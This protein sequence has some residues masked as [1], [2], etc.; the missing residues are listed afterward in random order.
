VQPP[1]PHAERSA[2]VVTVY[3]WDISNHDWDR[4][5]AAGRKVDLADARKAGISFATHKATEGSP[6][7][8]E[9]VDPYFGDHRTNALRDSF[10]KQLVAMSDPF[11]VAGSYHATHRGH[12]VDQANFWFDTVTAKYPGWRTH[13]C[14]IWQIDAEPL[15]GYPAPT[16]ADI[17]AMGHRL[18]ARGAARAQIVLYGPRWVYGDSLDGIPWRLWASSYVPD[19]GK[20][21]KRLYPGDNGDGWG[22]YS[23][24]T[25]L[26]VQYSS[27][28]TIGAQHTCDANAVRV[29]SEAAL[30][31]LFLG[32]VV[33]SD[34]LEEIMA[35]PGAPKDYPTFLAD[36]QHAVNHPQW[37]SGR[38][39]KAYSPDTV[40]RMAV[41]DHVDGKLASIAAVTNDTV[42]RVAKAQAAVTA[43]QAVVAKLGPAGQ[44]AVDGAA[45]A[46]AAA[47]AVIAKIKGL[48]WG[49]K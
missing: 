29:K 38:D 8:G 15:D 21:F 19:R 28:A 45:L 2:I 26:I 13:P 30:Q 12:A 7:A 46:A 41:G 47:D 40:L 44:V 31:A 3:G 34:L 27:G 24:Q 18:E 17:V 23:G 22:A 39:G 42:Q 6:G 9:Y 10:V 36:I 5:H 25:P 11:P 35:L 4:A 32:S 48:T 16:K 43:L 33:P 1:N 20:A 14:W 37:V 49:V